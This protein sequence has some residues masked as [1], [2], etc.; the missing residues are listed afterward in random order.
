MY[1]HNTHTT[2]VPDST[3]ERL[4]KLLSREVKRCIQK[5]NGRW[6]LVLEQES[7]DIV[8]DFLL[9]K[10]RRPQWI[11]FIGQCKHLIER[12]SLPSVIRRD[13][14]AF[15]FRELKAFRKEPALAGSALTDEVFEL[16]F[17]A[18][19]M[20]PEEAADRLLQAS[21]DRYELPRVGT[22]LKDMKQIIKLALQGWSYQ[23][24]ASEIGVCEKTVRNR[25]RRL[26]D[27]N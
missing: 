5:C 15:L 21:V 25:L 27:R 20:R 1:A 23:K 26:A 2:T 24:I 13:L 8:Q 6:R 12:G 14:R 9:R 17:Q 11:L 22:R 16:S 7:D 18:F 4:T 10:L 3:W 19:P